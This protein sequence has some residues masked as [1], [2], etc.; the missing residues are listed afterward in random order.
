M[1]MQHTFFGRRSA[2][3]RHF[4]RRREKS[5]PHETLLQCDRIECTLCARNECVRNSDIFGALALQFLHLGLMFA[6]RSIGRARTHKYS[7]V[8]C[9]FVS[10]CESLSNA[11]CALLCWDGAIYLQEQT[12]SIWYAL[13]TPISAWRTCGSVRVRMWLCAKSE[14]R[15][16]DAFCNHA[17]RQTRIFRMQT[18][19]RT[20]RTNVCSWRCAYCRMQRRTCC[21]CVFLRLFD[22][23]FSILRSHLCED[24]VFDSF[25]EIGA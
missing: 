2:R 18:L 20:S 22:L 1:Q 25:S 24:A 8:V 12:T 14:M 7:A 19:C 10:G 4:H 11:Y 16:D 9:A 6:C 13:K 3:L 23:L 5:R 17:K 21:V 15:R